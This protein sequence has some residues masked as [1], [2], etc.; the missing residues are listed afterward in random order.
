MFGDECF[1]GCIEGDGHLLEGVE[2]DVPLEVVLDVSQGHPHLLGEFGLC[3]LSLVKDE[4]DVFF[5]IHT[6]CEMVF[7][8]KVENI[9]SFSKWNAKNHL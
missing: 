4:Y 9:I 3:H 2:G 7:G 8:A 5:D 6:V 1:D